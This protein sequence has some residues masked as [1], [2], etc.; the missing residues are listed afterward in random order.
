MLTAGA[1]PMHERMQKLAVVVGRARVSCRKA[2]E[3]MQLV[4]QL[5]A[6]ALD[7]PA[8]VWTL[9]TLSSSLKCIQRL[10][11]CVDVRAMGVGYRHGL[12]LSLALFLRIN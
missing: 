10:P 7:D 4:L 11:V 12:R 9:R 2:V 3:G 8:R 6:Q 1:G 5:V